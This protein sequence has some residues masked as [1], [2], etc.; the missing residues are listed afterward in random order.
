MSTGMCATATCSTI[1][2]PFFTCYV[3]G[4]MEWLIGI[5]L[6]LVILSCW[7]SCLSVFE[8]IL[9]RVEDVVTEVMLAVVTELVSVSLREGGQYAG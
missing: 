7:I 5:V 3:R 4:L 2:L 1:A 8:K 6:A 9:A